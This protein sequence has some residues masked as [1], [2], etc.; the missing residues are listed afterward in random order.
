MNKTNYIDTLRTLTDVT[1]FTE[2]L[3]DAFYK[4]CA[5]RLN[6]LVARSGKEIGRVEEKAYEDAC[7]REDKYINKTFGYD[8]KAKY[9]GLRHE[10]HV[11]TN[12]W[13]KVLKFI[14]YAVVY[15]IA[16]GILGLI[17]K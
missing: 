6:E 14:V 11:K 8:R 12:V 15:I 9:D 16:M 7:E 5:A 1:P 10:E 2:M 13:M 17:T 3:N 4:K